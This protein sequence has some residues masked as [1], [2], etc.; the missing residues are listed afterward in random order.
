MICRTPNTIITT[1]G[2]TKVIEVYVTDENGDAYVTGS[3]ETLKFGVKEPSGSSLLITKDL[4]H[5]SGGI[6]SCTIGVNDYYTDNTRATAKFTELGEGHPYIYD[7]GLNKTS[8][9]EYYIV[10]PENPFYVMPNVTSYQPAA[11]T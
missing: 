11:S 8:T 2:A 6:Y 1:F 9:T 5:V 10:V 3:G 4:E 7:I